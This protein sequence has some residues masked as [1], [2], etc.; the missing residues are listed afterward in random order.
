MT[1]K[2]CQHSGKH[3]G[4]GVFLAQGSAQTAFLHATC[5][6]TPSFICLANRARACSPLLKHEYGRIHVGMLPSPTEDRRS[7]ASSA[8]RL[9]SNFPVAGSGNCDTTA[10]SFQ[11]GEMGSPKQCRSSCV[12]PEDEAPITSP[13]LKGSSKLSSLQSGTGCGGMGNGQKSGLCNASR[14]FLIRSS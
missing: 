2:K 4:D 7:M 12:L 8:A 9:L 3:I 6:Y 1:H 5:D 14:R 13:I 10:L 11:D